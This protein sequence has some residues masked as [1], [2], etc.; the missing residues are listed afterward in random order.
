VS[1]LQTT[2]VAGARAT[3]YQDLDAILPSRCSPLPTPPQYLVISGGPR[4]RNETGSG[5][6]NIAAAVLR[7]RA[8]AWNS[9][10]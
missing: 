1:F 5:R 7:M 3:A 2:H 6:R 10:R 4:R 9:R 8:V